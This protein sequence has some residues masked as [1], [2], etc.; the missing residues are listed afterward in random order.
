MSSTLPSHW[1]SGFHALIGVQLKATLQGVF[2]LILL[3][4]LSVTR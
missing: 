3:P 1:L 4:A 2:E